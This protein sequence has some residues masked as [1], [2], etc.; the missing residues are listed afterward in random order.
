LVV[1]AL[2]PKKIAAEYQVREA[3]MRGEHHEH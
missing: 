2:Y 1:T 3:S